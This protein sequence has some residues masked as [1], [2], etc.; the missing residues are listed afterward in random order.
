M[1]LGDWLWQ[2]SENES[3]RTIFTGAVALGGVALGGFVST[4]TAISIERGRRTREG[5]L[6]AIRL[7]V[8]L[9]RYIENCETSALDAG[10]VDADGNYHNRYPLPDLTFPD[11]IQ[12][13]SLPRS[14]MYAAFRLKVD[15]DDTDRGLAFIYSEIAVGPDREEY[16]V[17]KRVV[18]PKL[19]LAAIE[20]LRMLKDLFD[21]PLTDR[22]QYDP[23]DTFERLLAE[24]KQLDED[25]KAYI[26]QLE[27]ERIARGD[28]PG[29]LPPT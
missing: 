24:K 21:V 23:R 25:R 11:E 4:A 10:E 14:L 6:A 20:L 28:P 17:E 3:G 27:R 19:G 2:L 12:W 13:T 15:H 8:I 5:A 18:F 26:E 1:T 22:S 7:T 9:D 16:F 29:L